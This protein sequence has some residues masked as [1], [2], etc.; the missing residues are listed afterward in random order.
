M[1]EWQWESAEDEDGGWY[2]AEA[3]DGSWEYEE[4]GD[5]GPAPDNGG[6]F[7]S[8]TVPALGCGFLV[9]LLLLRRGG[10]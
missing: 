5:G 2:Y 6:C 7:M 3:D 4:W 9:S 8:A 1:S 10:R